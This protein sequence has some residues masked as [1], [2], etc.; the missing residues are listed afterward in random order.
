MIVKDP[1]KKACGFISV[2]W[3]TVRA[4]VSA[5]PGP[6]AVWRRYTPVVPA[7]LWLAR[8]CRCA[9]SARHGGRKTV[10]GRHGGGQCCAMTGCPRCP[11]TPRSGPLAAA[12]RG[13]PAL[14]Q[15]KVRGL[16]AVTGDLLVDEI[17]PGR[18]DGG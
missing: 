16:A 13:S 15:V 17:P 9:R 8:A 1:E 5:L 3:I 14:H 7:T 18:H 12:G 11:R 10:G 2:T 6:P 4:H